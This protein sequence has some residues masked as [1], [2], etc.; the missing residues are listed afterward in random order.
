MANLLRSKASLAGKS[1]EQELEDFS[2]GELQA[3]LY[4]W[5]FWARGK[6]IA[7]ADDWLIWLI[8]TGRG[9]GKTRTG[10]ETVRGYAE[11]GKV[12]RIA[13]VAA[14]AADYRDVMLEGDSGLLAVSPPQFRPEWTASRRKLEWP[15][16]CVA[17][18]YSAEEPDRLRGPQH[19]LA[20]CDELAAWKY[21]KK[22]WDN[23]MFGLRTKPGRTI[24]TTTPRPISLIISLAQDERTHVTGGDTY[25]NVENLS[26]VYKAQTIKPYEGTRIG[27][28][29]LHGELLLDSPGALW[30][31]EMLE[32]TR[33]D[34]EEPAI[35]SLTRIVVAIDPAV[36]SNEASHETGIV[37]A[38]SGLCGCKGTPELHG[39]IL[40]DCSMKG[41]PDSWA[42][43]ALQAYAQFS[44]DRVVGE[45]NN[46]G[47]LVETVIRTVDAS[48][49]FA[50][51]RASRGKIARAE[52]ISA[53]YE[54]GKVHH[55]GMFARLEDQMCL[56]I[57]TGGDEEE[58][59]GDDRVD[60]LV[61]A[62][63]EVMLS[64]SVGYWPYETVDV[65]TV[66]PNRRS[67]LI[68]QHRMPS[69]G[70]AGKSEM[71][72]IMRKDF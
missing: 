10:A 29:E 23:L 64:G 1:L 35:Q 28:Q 55:V 41:K 5:S 20:W 51:V 27:R 26:E 21:P 38:G 17:M 61:W 52:P 56:F 6:Q 18:C 13:L 8:L 19:G 22:T 34:S 42:R 71:S 53:L 58:A 66:E 37:V 43:R 47:D 57:P 54:Q 50:P 11:S 46:G 45:V 30:T 31:H 3:L 67:Q 65:G 44:C 2:D 32:A 48:A 12:A 24:I 69:G 7:P 59:D 36:T 72:G 9:W 68:D 39:F 4:D 25:E 60:A 16:G 49:S 15:N 40:E 70:R 62:L 33:V 14:T 63:T